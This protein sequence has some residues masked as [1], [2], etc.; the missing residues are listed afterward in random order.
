MANIVE[1]LTYAG[2]VILDSVIVTTAN[3]V[4]FN[5]INQV[6]GIE[7]FEDLFSPFMTGTITVLETLDL[8]S[9]FPLI[10]EEVVRIAFHTPTIDKKY[11]RDQSFYV[12]K[13]TDMTNSGD[14]SNIYVLHFISIE[15]IV[16]LNTKLS[17]TYN[18][19]VSDI[20]RKLMIEPDALN[21]KKPIN[22]EST[23]TVTAFTAN[24]WSPMHCINYAAATAHNDNN[25]ASYLFFENSFGLNFISL[26]TLYANPVLHEFEQN[27]YIRD[28]SVTGSAIKDAAKDYKK[29]QA[30]SAPDGFDYIDRNSN[31]MYGSQMITVD[32]ITKKYASRVY[33]W[34]DDYSKLK[35]LNPNPLMSDNAAARS[36]QAIIYMPKHYGNFN[37]YTD[38]TNTSVIQQRTSL[39]KSADAFKVSL[40]LLGRTDYTVGQKVQIKIP[41]K[42]PLHE[43]DAERIDKVTSGNYLIGAIA[44]RINRKT[45]ECTVELIKDSF[46]FDANKGSP[47]K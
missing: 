29:I 4:T 30:F 42:D 43:G 11:Y 21:S 12:Y 5:I 28:I 14:K 15:A 19:R 34:S 6:Q 36:Q 10:G 17:R 44:H 32:P 18:G 33:K 13:M 31:G 9:L 39:L 40:T 3:G 1:A 46:I 38:V 26:D 16:N 23:P 8:T 45:H 2:Q 20:A 37:G 27:N 25:S 41:A 24:F 22:I 7:L 47:K 35:H